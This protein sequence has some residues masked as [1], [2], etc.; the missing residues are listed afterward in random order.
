M[1]GTEGV[2][3]GKIPPCRIGYLISVSN[4]DTNKSRVPNTFWTPSMFEVDNSAEDAYTDDFE[5]ARSGLQQL[6]KHISEQDE[7]FRQNAEEFYSCLAKVGMDREKFIEVLDCLI[8]G[9]DQSDA[10]VHVS[11]F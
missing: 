11:W 10:Y 4:R 8:N 6:R 5:I 2:Q 3:K 9:S 1:A 7:T